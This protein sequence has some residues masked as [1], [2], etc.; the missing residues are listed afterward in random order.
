MSVGQGGE[1]GAEESTGRGFGEH[2]LDRRSLI[3]KAGIAGA[4]AWVAPVVIESMISPASAASLAPGT[5]RLRLSSEKCNPTP[6]LD[7]DTLPQANTCVPAGFTTTDFP[8]AVGT[9]LAAMFGISIDNCNRRF[10][11]NVT[12]TNPNV[13]FTAANAKGTKPNG[14]CNPPD[15]FTTTNVQWTN[16]SGA[17]NRDGFF[18]IITVAP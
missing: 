18:I 7:P 3:K 5:Y 13:T 9:D 8:V 2:S 12:T 6:V 11:I 10:A 17:I 1:T 14:A 4:A 16:G 15:V